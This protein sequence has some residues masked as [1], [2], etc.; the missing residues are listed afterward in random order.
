M[1]GETKWSLKQLL[2]YGIEGIISFNNKPIRVCFSI[3]TLLIGISLIYIIIILFQIIF[4]VIDS[5]DTLLL[6]QRC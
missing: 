5:Q 4:D 2:Q 3:G 6:L 1:A